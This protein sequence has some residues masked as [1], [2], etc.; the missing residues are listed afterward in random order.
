M[1]AVKALSSDAPVDAEFELYWL[2]GLLEG[3]GSFVKGPP[4]RPNCPI[5]QLAMTDGDVVERAARLLGRGVTPWDRKF[6]AP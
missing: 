1:Y 4:S 5:V 2:A 6:G 3:E